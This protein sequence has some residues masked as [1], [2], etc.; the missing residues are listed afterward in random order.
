MVSSEGGAA[1]E[2][3]ECMGRYTLCQNIVMPGDI[4]VY[5]QDGDDEMYLYLSE[6]GCWSIS[7]VAGAKDCFI[8]QKSENSPSP[9]KTI[10]WEYS[11]D[12]HGWRKDNTLKVYPCYF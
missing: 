11:S 12:P 8:Y 3:S 4:P 9:D 5:K 1:K 7:D 10:P 2:Q 6:L